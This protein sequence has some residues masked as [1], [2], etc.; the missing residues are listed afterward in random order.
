M[1][2]NQVLT[3]EAKIFCG[4]RKEYSQV[5]FPMEKIC[6]IIQSYTDEIG[7]C[8]TMTPTKFIYKNGNEPGVIIGVIQYPR[9]PL[10]NDELR[11]R[12]IKLAK[13]LL[14]ELKQIRISIVFP[15][16]TIM[17]ERDEDENKTNSKDN[18]T[19]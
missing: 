4:L 6:Q 2:D 18:S 14:V 13:Q 17:L 16:H 8:V 5:I 19:N 11:E 10:S 9:F 7:W 12:T 15:K 1:Y 3:W